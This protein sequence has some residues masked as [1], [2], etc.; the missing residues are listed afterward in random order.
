MEKEKLIEKVLKLCEESKS[1]GLSDEE[2]N[3]VLKLKAEEK[4]EILNDLLESDLITIEQKPNKEL[5]YFYNDPKEKEHLNSLTEDEVLIYNT[6]EMVQH[7]G[8]G[9]LELKSKVGMNPQQIRKII[10]KL[11]K[12]GYVKSFKP[13]NSKI[14]KMW[15]IASINPTEEM[16]G[17]IW[18]TDSSFDKILM[19][20]LIEKVSTMVASKGKS[21]KEDI[22]I[23]MK[24]FNTS[25]GQLKDQH[26]ES[27]LKV[28]SLDGDLIEMPNPLQ[29]ENPIFEVS[30]KHDKY[31]SYSTPSISICVGCPV[32]K[33]CKV[34][35]VISPENCIYF[36]NFF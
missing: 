3:K 16:T 13:I 30:G 10:S 23:G 21:T 25:K 12:K 35:G 18:Y 33:D 15:I 31:F 29:A 20:S 5:V 11:E 34:G 22:L 14:K 26:I 28:M 17:G 7:K 24:G 32:K 36:E 8:I 1:K 2:L 27:I 9:N 6:I 4:I 19:D